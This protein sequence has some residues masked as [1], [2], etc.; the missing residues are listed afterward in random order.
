MA[1]PE[2]L[3]KRKIKTDNCDNPDRRLRVTAFLK[4]IGKNFT[5]WGKVE[6]ESC[7]ALGRHV[8][9]MSKL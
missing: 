6:M 4:K 7:F 8:K 1:F 3:P 2:F 9:E 5:T